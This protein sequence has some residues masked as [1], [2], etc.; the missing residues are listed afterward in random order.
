MRFYQ[1]NFGHNIA[2]EFVC[3]RQYRPNSI[4]FNDINKKIEIIIISNIICSGLNLF[5][6]LSQSHGWQHACC[7]TQKTAQHFLN[8]SHASVR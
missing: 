7:A 5:Q 3:D 8:N 6:K 2:V 1:V 4:F